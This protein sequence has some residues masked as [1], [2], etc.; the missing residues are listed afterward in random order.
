M[1]HV[2][3]CQCVSVSIFMYVQRVSNET[4]KTSYEAN[5]GA[6]ESGQNRSVGGVE[7]TSAVP[8]G[9]VGGHVQTTEEAGDA[10][11]GCRRSGM[12]PTGRTRLPDANQPGTPKSDDGGEGDGAGVTN[13]G[14][15]HR[16]SLATMRPKH[17]AMSV[18]TSCCQRRTT[19]QP[20][21]RRRR[22]LR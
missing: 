2:K 19:R 1:F 22:K 9:G 15:E 3:H 5:E 4:T 8:A 17:P 18:S 21:R 11:A 6:T 13:P 10:A 20:A 16:C 7:K 14:C 12:V